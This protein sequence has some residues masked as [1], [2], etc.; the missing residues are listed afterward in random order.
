MP[1]A[2]FLR[3]A[4]DTNAVTTS[5][6]SSAPKNQ[7]VEQEQ[8]HCAHD[9]HDP[10][11]DIILAHEETTDPSA[12]KRPGDS[13]QNGDDATA[14]IFSGHQQFGNGADDKADDQ[15]PNDRMCAEV[16]MGSDSD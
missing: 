3:S 8:N 15:N 4:F 1:S 7:S 6:R 11:S 13:E 12:D 16:H 5:R 9:R 2:R 10:T 14:G